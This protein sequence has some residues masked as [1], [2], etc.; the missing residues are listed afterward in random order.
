[1]NCKLKWTVIFPCMNKMEMKGKRIIYCTFFKNHRFVSCCLLPPFILHIYVKVYHYSCYIIV[2]KIV[3]LCL[4]SRLAIN[5]AW[6]D[7]FFRGAES[8]QYLQ[9]HFKWRQKG[10]VIRCWGCQRDSGPDFR[11]TLT[12]IA[13]NAVLFH[14]RIA[15]T[16]LTQ[17]NVLKTNV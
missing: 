2:N 1:M 6:D 5:R 8:R 7:T 13:S 11:V 9:E 14:L 12:L 4:R 3:G 10:Y 15:L 17:K 16:A